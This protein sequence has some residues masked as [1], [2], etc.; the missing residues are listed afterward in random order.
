MFA[1]AG[2]PKACLPQKKNR[3]VS[4]Q[5]VRTCDGDEDDDDDDH[6]PMITIE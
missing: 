1:S 2:V 6:Y 3:Y 4:Y 5:E